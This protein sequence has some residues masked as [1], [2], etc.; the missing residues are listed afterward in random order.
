MQG[1]VVITGTGAG[2][3]VLGQAV[4]PGLMDRYLPDRAWEGQMSDD[5]ARPV[6]PDLRGPVAADVSAHRAFDDMASDTGP[7]L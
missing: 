1:V 3:G 2:V 6:S 7:L 5:P 4:A